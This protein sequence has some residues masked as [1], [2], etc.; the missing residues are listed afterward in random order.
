[1]RS[2][3]SEVLRFDIVAS[4]QMVAKITNGFPI[5]RC[6]WSYKPVLSGVM[7]RRMIRWLDSACL[8]KTSVKGESNYGTKKERAPGVTN[9]I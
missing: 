4:F 3:H 8:K 6:S 9:G 7:T 5:R 2:R 1:V